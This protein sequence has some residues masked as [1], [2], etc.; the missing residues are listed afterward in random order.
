VQ[1]QLN[2]ATSRGNAN[3][4]N[5]LF[6]FS[7]MFNTAIEDIQLAV[8]Y[9]VN[10]PDPNLGAANDEEAKLAIGSAE[11]KCLVISRW[12]LSAASLSAQPP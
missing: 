4:K 3:S 9:A 5:V 12:I 8:N 6:Y 10:L 2:L 1:T 11:F 7:S